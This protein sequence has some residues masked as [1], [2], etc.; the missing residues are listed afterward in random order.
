LW[1]DSCSLRSTGKFGGDRIAAGYNSKTGE[2]GDRYIC[3]RKP[4]I[5]VKIQQITTV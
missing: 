2:E 5:D 4:T 3:V 1:I